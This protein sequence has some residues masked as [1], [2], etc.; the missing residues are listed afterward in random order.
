VLNVPHDVTGESGMGITPVRGVQT[1]DVVAAKER[2]DVVDNEQLAMIAAGTSRESEP[3]H[4]QRV[5]AYCDVLGKDE[6]GA[7]D[8]Q[9]GEFIE[10]HID[11]HSTVGRIDQRVFERLPNG[12]ALPDEAL[13]EDPRLGLAD[14]VQHVA[15][16][17]FTVGI[18]GDLGTAASYRARAQSRECSR[19]AQLLAP[20]G[21][22]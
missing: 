2:D 6:E 20:E 1:A 10:D 13:E 22:D 18:D 19:L 12:V 15:V 14:G 5:P 16:K 9:I 4:D 7:R 11:L 17:I 8:Y 21:R 3:G